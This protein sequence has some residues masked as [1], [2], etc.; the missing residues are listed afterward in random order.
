VPDD[1]EDGGAVWDDVVE[2]TQKRLVEEGLYS[3]GDRIPTYE[4]VV[5][6]LNDWL[7]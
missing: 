3:E 5:A 2:R 4:A 1:T 6:G 7:N